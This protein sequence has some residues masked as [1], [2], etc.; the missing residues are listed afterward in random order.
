M[1][2]IDVAS[3]SAL[4]S[5]AEKLDT[6]NILLTAIASKDGNLPIK[7][8]AGVQS[9]VRMGLAPKVFAI[10]DQLVCNHETYG[11]LVWDIIGFDHEELSNSNRIHSMTIQLHSVLDAKLAYDAPEALYYAQTEL[12]AGTYNFTLL[13]G[14]DTAYGGG[15]TYYFTLTKPVPAGG[16]IVF[17]WANNQQA[18]NCKIS[19]YETHTS[20]TPIEIVS[21]AEGNSGTALENTNHTHRIKCGSGRWSQSAIRQWLNSDK[22]SGSWWKP[23]NNYDR[24]VDY[25][26]TKNGFMNGL[27]KDFCSVIGDVTKRTALSTAADGGGYED[28]TERIFVVSKSEIYGG[29][30]NGIAEGTPY[31]Y[32]SD[33]SDLSS[34]GV[35][36]DTNRVKYKNETPQYWWLR[37]PITSDSNTVRIVKDTGYISYYHASNQHGIAPACCIY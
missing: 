23:S 22:A 17:D 20:T 30:E 12:S 28:T 7:D 14:Y 1:S 10:G 21:V 31:A 32:Y 24:P 25:A 15:K 8:W 16:H 19:T 5:V 26:A 33:F 27:D 11:E 36:T 2:Q 9:I 29:D 37:S 13:S 34:A 18:I 3:N 6:Q 4:L 35:G